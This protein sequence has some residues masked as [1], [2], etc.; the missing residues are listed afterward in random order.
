MRQPSTGYRAAIDP[1]LLAA[2]LA[3]RAGAVLLDLGCG[4]GA[5]SLCLLA[6]RPDVAVIGVEIDPLLAELARQNA[7]LNGFSDRFTVIDGAAEVLTAQALPPIAALFSN[8]PFH[9]P[10]ATPSP[11]ARRAR[12][13]HGALLSD[14]T[15][16]AARLLPHRGTFSLI[17]R[18]DG[19]A[20]VLAALT[21]ETRSGPRFGGIRV[22]PLWPRAGSPAKRLLIQASLG[23]RAPL[24]L[25]SGLVLHGAGSAY[26]PQTEAILRG[27]AAWEMPPTAPV[28]DITP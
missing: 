22:A 1:V 15:A 7:A 12:A 26:T 4:V 5:A 19:L 18:A 16:L 9:D 3:P 2:S 25:Q 17:Y 23:S 6:R 8:P 13:T 21:G 24:V 14:W 28:S 27:E 20:E 11:E 10:A